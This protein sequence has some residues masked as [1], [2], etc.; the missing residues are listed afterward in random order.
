VTPARQG[1]TPEAQG[2]GIAA[3]VLALVSFSWGF[4]IVKA[5]DLEAAPISAWRLAIG[6]V[7]LVGAA[8]VL[9]APWPRLWAMPVAAGLAF[10]VHQLLYVEAT[11]RTSIA[12]VTLIGALQP[13]VVAMVSRRTVGEPVPRALLACSAL[14]VAGVGVVVL[15]SVGQAERSLVG[16][17]VA[18]ANLFAFTAYFLC[19]KRAR[20]QGA[21]TLTLT[22]TLV[23]VAFAVVLPVALLGGGRLAVTPV[24][25]TLIAVLALGPGNGHLL[26]TWA[27]ARVSAALSSLL[28][29]AVPVLATLWAYLVLG[30]AFGPLHL[31]GMAI[32]VAASEGGRRVE[33]ATARRRRAARETV[34]ST[35]PR[36]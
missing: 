19:T 31:L 35:A 10:G 12:I 32:V 13:L 29:A 17:L 11:Q 21:P 36:A 2:A 33:R 27:H 8:L 4:I 14:A 28:L 7:T 23:G 3:I 15:A 34:L 16:D 18:V 20:Q 26:V 1:A 30:E 25:L 9:R 5:L 24:E 6:V 22:A